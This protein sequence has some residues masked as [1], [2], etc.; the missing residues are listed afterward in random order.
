MYVRDDQANP[1]FFDL[2][3]DQVWPDL[4][5]AYGGVL[6][7]TKASPFSIGAWKLGGTTPLTQKIFNVSETY[8]GPIYTHEVFEAGATLVLPLSECK[9]E[10]EIACRVGRDD[11]DAWCVCAEMPSSGIRDLPG[12]GVTALV[13]DRCAAGALVLGEACP[14][15]D[16]GAA[17]TA[18]VDLIFEGQVLTNGGTD[19]LVDTPLN[20][21]RGFLTLAKD[22]GFSPQP[23]QWIAAGGMTPCVEVPR[24]GFYTVKSGSQSFS[25]TLDIP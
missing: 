6:Q 23:G 21:A 2:S 9:I 17:P 4:S 25:F 8:F 13:A 14:I 12:K 16:I 18:G 7:L 5:G 1:G 24:A 15:D 10:L 22:H 19:G 3:P 20:I 11:I